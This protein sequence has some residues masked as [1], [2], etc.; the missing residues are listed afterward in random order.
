MYIRRLTPF[1]TVTQASALLELSRRASARMEA[2]NLSYHN[3]NHVGKMLDTLSWFLE[4][5]DTEQVK[6]VDVATV[7]AAVLYHDVV[8]IPGFAQNE[9]A[10]ALALMYDVQRLANVKLVGPEV[11]VRSERF[12]DYE[13]S[14]RLI[15]AT[16]ISSHLKP[17]ELSLA[18]EDLIKDLDLCSMA[19]T[20]SAFIRTQFRLA[21]EQDP[22]LLDMKTWKR[23]AIEK[24]K[25][26]LTE[27]A[28]KD[29]I[30]R[31]P[32]FRSKL[33]A[34]ARENIAKFA[35]YNLQDD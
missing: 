35:K 3:S 16:H 13:V 25:E 5:E 4:S 26:F 15:M 6:P 17:S 23:G 18:D 10:S 31:L 30:F 12:I 22:G 7:C 8:Y 2:N 21:Q 34:R 32:F 24:S 28:A 11:Q 1:V 14:K 27:V 33:E 19:S 9:E 20:Y 29:S